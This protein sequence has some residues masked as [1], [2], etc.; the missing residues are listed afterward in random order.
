MISHFFLDGLKDFPGPLV[1]HLL[2]E[3]GIKGLRALKSVSGEECKMVCNAAYFDSETYL[4]SKGIL[5]GR[6][7]L[8]K[9]DPDSNMLLST[10][11]VP[12]GEGKTLNELSIDDHRIK[13]YKKLKKQILV[14]LSFS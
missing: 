14:N 2:K 7:D 5:R 4:N 10:V 6:L 1:K 8:K 13:A 12:E 11:F 9:A 3:A